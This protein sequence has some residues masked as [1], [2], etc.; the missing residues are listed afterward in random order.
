MISS[1]PAS[2]SGVIWSSY[3]HLREGVDA[4]PPR[5]WP[6]PMRSRRLLGRRKAEAIMDRNRTQHRGRRRR[7]K[8]LAGTRTPAGRQTSGA[9]Q[10][11]PYRRCRHRHGAGNGNPDSELP[12]YE[13]PADALRFEQCNSTPHSPIGQRPDRAAE[14]SVADTLGGLPALTRTIST[15]PVICHARDL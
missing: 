1:Q 11:R 9:L 15:M 6:G 8:R 10:R 13:A 3:C 4:G 14:P 2:S 12:T 7:P 5:L